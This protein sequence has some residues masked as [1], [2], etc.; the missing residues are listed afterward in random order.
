MNTHTHTF[1]PCDFTKH[2]S[3]CVLL[4]LYCLL[5][6]LRC[7][8]RTATCDP[9]QFRILC[10][11]K[12]SSTMFSHFSPGLTLGLLSVISL[13]YTLESILQIWSHFL[14][15]LSFNALIITFFFF[16]HLFAISSR[17]RFPSHTVY[18]ILPLYFPSF[19]LP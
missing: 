15:F 13:P 4:W 18:S 16:V 1:I 6:I 10:S 7:H 12:L 17:N 5:I 19:L 3:V 2:M 8:L 9:T 14:Q 11:F